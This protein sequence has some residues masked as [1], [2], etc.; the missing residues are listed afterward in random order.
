MSKY[1]QA[2]TILEEA[3]AGKSEHERV[4]LSVGSLR[5]LLE[6]AAVKAGEHHQAEAQRTISGFMGPLMGCAMALEGIADAADTLPQQDAEQGA[7]MLAEIV[8]SVQSRLESVTDEMES[9][10]K[11]RGQM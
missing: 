3:L 4:E 7:Y 2:A 10:S 5:E 9:A 6:A 11:G 1:T 8:R